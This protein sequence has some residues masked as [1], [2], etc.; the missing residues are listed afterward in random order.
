MT[1]RCEALRSEHAAS[2]AE[3]FVAASSPCFCRF[4]TFEGDDNAW[5]L[6]AAT[7]PESNRGELVTAVTQGGERGVVALAGDRVV[8]WLKLAPSE[9]VPKM[10]S[11]RLY[12]AEPWFRSERAGV[13]MVGCVLVH[14][15]ERR[16]GVARDLVLTSIAVARELGARALEAL[17]RKLEP[18]AR[19]ESFWNG[20]LSTLEAAGF[21]RVAGVDG[22]PVLRI[23]L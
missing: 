11:R 1:V 6:R 2:L 20:P 9:A 22:Y 23:D 8:G 17:P 7:A 18:P 5:Q 3:L 4:W 10:F 13:F 19:D 16:R 14:P 12:R 15:A 21:V